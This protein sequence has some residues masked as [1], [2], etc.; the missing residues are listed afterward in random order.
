MIENIKKIK[1]SATLIS[2]NVLKTEAKL[3]RNLKVEF[4]FKTNVHPTQFLLC[5]S[6][7]MKVFSTLKSTLK[8][9]LLDNQRL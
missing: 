5:G 9:L 8:V 1:K 4:V 2:T 7:P 6:Y 3:S